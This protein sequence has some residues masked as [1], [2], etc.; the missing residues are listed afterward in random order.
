M[1]ALEMV[2]RSSPRDP[3][4]RRLRCV[5]RLPEPG[6]SLPWVRCAS[7]RRAA[8]ASHRLACSAASSGPAEG[9]TPRQTMSLERPPGATTFSTVVK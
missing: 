2:L 1:L 7:R 6:A 4:T 8:E 3:E 9:E 5:N